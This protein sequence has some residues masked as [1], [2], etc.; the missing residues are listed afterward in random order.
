M[1]GRARDRRR[2]TRMRRRHPRPPAADRKT[3][4]VAGPFGDA[5]R[6][7]LDSIATRGTVLTLERDVQH[8]D[9]Y[10]RTLAYLWLADGR[11]VNEEMLRAGMAVVSV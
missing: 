8:R 10:D 6:V 1:Y 11:M 4:A 5:A 2:Y 3:R 9:R 7:A